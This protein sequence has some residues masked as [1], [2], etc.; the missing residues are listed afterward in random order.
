MVITGVNLPGRVFRRS[1]GT[2]MEN[3]HVGV[4]LRR[5]PVQMVRADATQ[6]RWEFDVDVVRIDGLVDFRGPVVQGKR[7]DRF[8]YV[9]WGDLDAAHGFVMFR[10]AKLMLS[11]I[12]PELIESA[13]RVG[14]L[15][16]TV[17]LTDDL[18]G[19]RCARVDPPALTWSV[20]PA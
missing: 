3:V 19:P 17:D 9:T 16:V 8:I 20:P 12:E 15:A 1:D 2:A 11:R 14:R 18:G 10:R 5:D 13:T 4:Q 7:G 6:A